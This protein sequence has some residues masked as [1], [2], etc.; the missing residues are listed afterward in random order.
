MI[1]DG[2]QVE[3][4][5]EMLSKG[6]VTIGAKQGS[7]VIQSPIT[8]LLCPIMAIGGVD[9][10]SCTTEPSRLLSQCVESLE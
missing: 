1:G 4:F 5:L 10:K 8:C 9:V 7:A 2:D 6:L 3:S